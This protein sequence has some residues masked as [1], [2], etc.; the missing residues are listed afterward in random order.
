MRS[1]TV[2]CLLAAALLLP[3]V[4]L[5]Q[6]AGSSVFGLV[7][8]RTAIQYAVWSGGV[9]SR[10]GVALA[11]ETPGAVVDLAGQQHSIVLGAARDEDWWNVGPRIFYRA[12]GV[13]ELPRA[14]KYQTGPV[15]Y[16]TTS[17]LGHAPFL[18]IESSLSLEQWDSILVDAEPFEPG[19]PRAIE[20]A[21]W[22]ASLG[23]ESVTVFV[24]DR[25]T[26]M[27]VAAPC[28]PWVRLLGIVDPAAGV[29]PVMTDTGTCEGQGIDFRRPFAL[30]RR[31]GRLF[32]L[33]SFAA[34][35]ES[36]GELWEVAPAGLVQI[37]GR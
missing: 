3:T 5:A 23:E 35:L 27:N 20:A 17:Q 32:V 37:I 24:A 2:Q 28:V 36:D 26:P 31:G 4:A 9:W 21:V 6:E 11:E 29:T 19:R 14:G 30:I 1:R 7:D 22:R 8:G 10:S 16:W 25:T 12:N 33:M 15:G 34:G 13:P 18:E